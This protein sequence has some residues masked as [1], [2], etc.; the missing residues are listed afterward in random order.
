VA[1]KPHRSQSTTWL[2]TGRSRRSCEARGAYRRWRAAGPLGFEERRRLSRG[3]YSR[4]WGRPCMRRSFGLGP[5]PSRVPWSTATARPVRSSTAPP[6]VRRPGSRTALCNSEV[7]RLGRSSPRPGAARRRRRPGTRPGRQQRR[8][9]AGS[10]A[11]ESSAVAW[12]S[13]SAPW[14]RVDW[15]RRPEPM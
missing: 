13:L 2:C 9:C 6:A 8:I 15:A 1:G 14:G 5:G 11:T 12:A 3:C 4:A 10:V 7:L